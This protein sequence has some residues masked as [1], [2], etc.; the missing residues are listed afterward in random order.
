MRR[1]R[2]GSRNRIA[3]NREEVSSSLDAGLLLLLLDVDLGE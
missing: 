3:R 2:S 1:S